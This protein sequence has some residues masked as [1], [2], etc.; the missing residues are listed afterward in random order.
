MTTPRCLK[1]LNAIGFAGP[2]GFQGYGIAADG[3]AI[4]TPTMA[5]WGKLSSQAAAL[6]MLHKGRNMRPRHE[7]YIV[8][9]GF[10]GIEAARRWPTRRSMSPSSTAATT[11]SSS[12]CST[13]WRRP[14]CRRRT[15]RRHPPHPARAGRTA[16]SSL[17]EISGL[18]SSGGTSCWTAAHRQYDYLILAAG[19]DPLVLRPRRVG[20]RRPGPQE[21]R[22]RDRAAPPDPAGVRVGRVRGRP[23]AAVAALTF[24][25]VGGG[26]TGVELAG[27]I[28]EIAGETIPDDSGISIRGRRACILFRAS[29]G[30]FPPFRPT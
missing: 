7:V 9:G 20:D 17:A 27:A 19:R 24:A 23:R 3:R 16:A 12:R 5:A 26:P 11:T 6:L 28:K 21:H 25:I 8:G 10:A 22:R 1:K 4:L 2:I 30:C 29:L 14:R 18:T 15:S 13:R